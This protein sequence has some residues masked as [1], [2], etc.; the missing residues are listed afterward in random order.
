MSEIGFRDWLMDQ[1]DRDDP[2]GDLANDFK[3]DKSE[4]TDSSS[5]DGWQS[6]FASKFSYAALSA[7]EEAWAE[8]YRDGPI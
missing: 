2:V 5:Y 8:Y 6:F 7:F 1:V 4:P 3:L